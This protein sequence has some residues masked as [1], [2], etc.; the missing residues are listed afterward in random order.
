MTEVFNALSGTVPSIGLVII[1]LVLHKA[2]ILRLLL[3]GKNGKSG[4]GHD[5]NVSLSQ[6]RMELEEMKTN[7]FHSLESRLDLIIGKLDKMSETLV[8]IKYQTK[9]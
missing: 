1:L 8:D 7:H 2:G 9:K 3:N 4:N 5:A 6:L